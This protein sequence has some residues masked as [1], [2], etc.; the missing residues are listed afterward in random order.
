MS[1]LACRGRFQE[2]DSLLLGQ[3]F[4]QESNPSHHEERHKKLAP[5]MEVQEVLSHQGNKY[6]LVEV[7]RKLEES[8]LYSAKLIELRELED[9]RAK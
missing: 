3:Y 8:P 2:S 4:P 7:L 6:K 9:K 1:T 5:S